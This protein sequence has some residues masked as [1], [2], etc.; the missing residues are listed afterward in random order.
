MGD[1]QLGKKL[2]GRNNRLGTVVS[3]TCCNKSWIDTGGHGR[4]REATGGRPKHNPLYNPLA[5]E[6]IRRAR[7]Y[8]LL[9]KG[10]RG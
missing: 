7:A 2:W 1:E 6:T 9:I 4:P 8:K 3:E 10:E 5:L